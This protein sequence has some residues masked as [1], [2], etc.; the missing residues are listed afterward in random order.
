MV[1]PSDL[2]QRVVDG[3][4]L[5]GQHALLVEAAHLQQV[6]DDLAGPVHL[7]PAAVGPRQAAHGAIDVGAAARLKLSSRSRDQRRSSRVE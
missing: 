5:L 1:R 4:G 2:L 7:E 6:L 3:P